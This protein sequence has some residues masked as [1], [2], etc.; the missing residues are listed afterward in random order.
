MRQCSLDLNIYLDTLTLFRRS[1]FLP[2]Q[3]K[4]KTEEGKEK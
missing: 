1:N 4:E 3:K 2:I